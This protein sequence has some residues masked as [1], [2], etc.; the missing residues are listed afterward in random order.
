MLGSLTR[1]GMSWLLVIARYGEF[2]LMCR[3]LLPS[4]WELSGNFQ[5][6]KSK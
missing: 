1:M 2:A 6:N 3:V 4:P 5:T